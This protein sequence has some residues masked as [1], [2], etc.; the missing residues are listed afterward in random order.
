MDSEFVIELTDSHFSNPAGAISWNRTL[1][2]FDAA[3]FAGT[4]VA[5]YLEVDASN[6]DANDFYVKLFDVTHSADK[7]SD[8]GGLGVK[9]PHG[10][11]AMTTYTS[12]AW[13]PAAGL[14]TYQLIT[15]AGLTAYN[16][17]LG[18]AR[19]RIVV[20]GVTKA[21]V[22]IP[23]I[24]GGVAVNNNYNDGSAYLDTSVGTGYGQ[25][26]P[27]QYGQFLYTAAEWADI[28]AGSGGVVAEYVIAAQSATYAVKAALCTAGSTTVLPGSETGSLTNTAYALVRCAI[29]P[30]DLVDGRTYEAD[31]KTA[32]ASGYVRIHSASLYVRMSN[33]AG[34]SKF[35]VYRRLMS[36][37]SGTASANGTRC[38]GI[39]VTRNYGGPGTVV[40]FFTEATGLD[41]TS[42]A[43]YGIGDCGT[44]V[45]AAPSS[46]IAGSKVTLPSTKGRVRSSA[47]TPPQSGEYVGAYKAASTGTTTLSGVFAV[48]KMAPSAYAQVTGPL[49]LGIN[50]A[51]DTNAGNYDAGVLTADLQYLLGRGIHHV[52]VRSPYYDNAADIACMKAVSLVAKGLGM[53]VT[54]GISAAT[55][56]AAAAQAAYTT[57]IDAFFAWAQ[58][59]SIDE[60]SVGNEM[61]LHVN[62]TTMLAA[63]VRPFVRGLATRVKG[64]GYTGKV[65]YAASQGTTLLGWIFDGNAGNLDY[66]SV[67]VYGVSVDDADGWF[68]Y[69]ARQMANVY[70][71]RTYVSEWNIYTT[72]ATVTAALSPAQIATEV[73]SRLALLRASAFSRAFFFT[74]KMLDD[75]FS[76]KT[77]AGVVQPMFDALWPEITQVGGGS[78]GRFPLLSKVCRGIA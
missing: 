23:L 41:L 10:A 8:N 54:A 31:I 22:Q 13:T 37:S 9:I 20:K 43:T 18:S 52:R 29:D 69:Y 76:C 3:D 64:N 1:R 63:D 12:A 34:L 49:A 62:G 55:P 67:N 4:S 6:A 32:N 47:W 27:A 75:A 42:E 15:N 53:Y 74:W 65:T 61:E 26:A 30:A 59:N 17:T 19:I 66:V 14:N 48:I 36:Q 45:S 58:T 25:T 35:L 11:S 24:A 44:S 40:N 28:I 71:V 21:V 68:E 57:A 38:R 2:A 51:N 39:L 73:T 16:A 46:V 7:L 72:W 60:C 70:G 77:Q 50:V 56:F 5:Y 33:A 78:S